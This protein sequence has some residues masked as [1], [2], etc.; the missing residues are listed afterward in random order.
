[1]L[2]FGCKY[3]GGK[4]CKCILLHMPPSKQSSSQQTSTHTLLP[5]MRTIKS[6]LVLIT[7]IQTF[8]TFRVLK[9]MVFIPGG[10]PKELFKKICA[11]KIIDLS[12]VCTLMLDSTRQISCTP[13]LRNKL[14]TRQISEIHEVPGYI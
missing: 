2:K 3:C 14:C 4:F 7:Y 5:Y 12:P 11:M 9:F 8:D 10:Y 1:M 6:S 13:F